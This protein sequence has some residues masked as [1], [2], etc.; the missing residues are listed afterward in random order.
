MTTE[1][2]KELTLAARVS[3]VELITGQPGADDC[4]A[5]CSKAVTYDKKV[6][7]NTE[8]SNHFS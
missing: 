1:Q 2:R 3:R 6:C 5:K 8:T 4:L 7:H